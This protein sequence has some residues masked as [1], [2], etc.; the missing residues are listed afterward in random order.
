MLRAL[1]S[2]A[3]FA[4]IMALTA[5]NPCLADD[6]PNQIV[7]LISPFTAG[8][9]NDFTARILAQKLSE[10]WNKSVIVEDKPG[11]NGDIGTDY[12]ARSTP[13]GHTLLLTT[14]AT[15]VINP[16]L[17]KSN[18]RFDPVK[19]FAPVSLLARQ[20]F[21]LVVNP[22]V[23]AKTLGE[24]IDYARANPDKL[25]FGSSGAGGGAHLSGEMLKT[26]LNIKM[27]HVPYKGA[28]AALPA[29]VAGHVDFMFVAIL[30]ARPFVE[31]GTL[32]AL[33]V[34][35]KKRNASMP[36]VPAVSEYPGLEDF[37]ADL[38]YGLLAPAKTDPAII[39]KIHRATV[40]ALEDP[41]VK[42]RFEQFGTVLIGS[43]P[44]E[45][46][47]DIKKDIEKWAVVIKAAGMVSQ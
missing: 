24:L 42:A 10:E 21:V 43:S 3:A 31:N 14:N 26:F 4:F 13:D 38:W 16:Q 29:V 7:R 1:L 28:S 39:D 30:T 9:G 36:N 20:P 46:A 35:S 45:F 25:N 32:R 22:K 41:T 40:R 6:Y 8:G 5:I 27:T 12:V 47:A 15:I 17:F 2:Y 37:E 19:D 33:A 34:T 18:V 44:S 11:G 23:P